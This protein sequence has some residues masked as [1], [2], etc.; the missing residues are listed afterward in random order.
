MQ[1]EIPGVFLRVCAVRDIQ[2]EFRCSAPIKVKPEVVILAEEGGILRKE[3][4][5]LGCLFKHGYSSFSLF[6]SRMRCAW[7]RFHVL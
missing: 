5:L 6:Q 7:P 1:Y 3:S 4:A 2:S